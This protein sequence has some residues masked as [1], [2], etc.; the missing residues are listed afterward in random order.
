MASLLRRALK[1]PLIHMQKSLSLQSSIAINNAY[2][3]SRNF[4]D[5]PK[6]ASTPTT[7]TVIEE[8]VTTQDALEQVE[9]FEMPPMRPTYQV[10]HPLYIYKY[11]QAYTM[12]HIICVFALIII[13]PKH[14]W[15]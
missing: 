11:Y 12:Y 15:N 14:Q 2:R 6:E 1:R 8:Q 10:Y 7:T 4:A 9:E 13:R 3:Q 5:E